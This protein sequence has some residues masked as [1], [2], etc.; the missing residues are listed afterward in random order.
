MNQPDDIVITEKLSKKLFGDDDA[1]GKIIRI[2]SS[3]NFKVSAVLKDLP[4]NTSFEFEYLLPWSYMRKIS[5]DDSSW[6]NNSITTFIL[7]KPG[8]SVTAFNNKIRN[9]T[10]EHTKNTGDQSTTQV[11]A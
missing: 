10:M 2:D 3:D 9:V 8:V 5:Y 11:F 7:I 1:I 4:N 6:G